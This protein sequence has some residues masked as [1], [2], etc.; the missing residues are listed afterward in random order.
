VATCIADLLAHLDH[1]TAG[2]SIQAG[3]ATACV[4][5]LGSLADNIRQPALARGE[6]AAVARHFADACHTLAVTFEEQPGRLADTAG[7]LTDACVRRVDQLTDDE[8]WTVIAE[9]AAPARRCAN[10]VAAS[11]PYERVPQLLAMLDRAREV[12]LAAADDP[13]EP[14]VHG[15]L[16]EPIP[17]LTML[18]RTSPEIVAIEAVAT[19]A[20]D[21]QRHRET[22][23]IRQLLGICLVGQ[24]AARCVDSAHGTRSAR[25]W[26]QVRD[27]LSLYAD[28]PRRD[29]AT[30]DPILHT[31][32]QGI[33]TLT[34]ASRRAA[35]ATEMAPVLEPLLGRLAIG[36]AT[37]L[38]RA[39]PNL[40]V[41]RGQRPLREAR[42][43]EWLTRQTYRPT[44]AD[45]QPVL[46]RLYTL[47]VPRHEIAEGAPAAGRERIRFGVIRS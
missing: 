18:D 46:D 36:C 4:Q 25:Q 27:E 15:R 41:P 20:A 13:P 43:S 34:A 11:G 35:T 23:T 9:L 17:S 32:I 40:L 31:V 29:P 45:M 44:A 1:L 42:V 14:N 33:E 37:E 3:D 28:R 8:R 30:D 24:A 19:L 2:D 6:R 21:L 7:V 38:E 12:I 22:F 10:A 16:T 39:R 26:R 5:A 47:T